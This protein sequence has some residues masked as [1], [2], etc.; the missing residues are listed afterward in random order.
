VLSIADEPE[1]DPLCDFLRELRLS[2]TEVAA[3]RV[4]AATSSR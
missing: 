2:G 3:R 4:G 1:L